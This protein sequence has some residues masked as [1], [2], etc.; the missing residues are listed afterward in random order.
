[1][2]VPDASAVSRRIRP[3]L[4]S[5]VWHYQP[6]YSVLIV[7][8]VWELSSRFALINPYFFP[9]PSKI[10][11]KALELTFTGDLLMHSGATFLRSV[12]ALGLSVV[13]GMPLGILIARFRPF[14][15]FFDPLISFGFP[16]PKITLWPIFVLWFGFHDVSKILLTAFACVLPI[17]SA[18]QLATLNVDKYLLWS[19]RNMGTSEYRLL[20]KVIFRAAFPNILT[21]VQTVVPV[22]FIVTVLTEML[23]GGVGLGAMIMMAGQLADMPTLFVGIIASS[24]LGYCTMRAVEFARRRLL[25]WHEET[26]VHQ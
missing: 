4:P 22:A 20:W 13:V 14:R 3:P 11:A 15:W 5:G 10:A 18:T 16:I 6:I 21:G 7:L 24:F 12:V 25:V 2:T 26:V 17:V 8:L 1:M 19:A 23:S 9:Q